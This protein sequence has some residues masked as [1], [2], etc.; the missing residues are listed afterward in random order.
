MESSWYSGLCFE[1]TGE[2]YTAKLLLPNVL[3]KK[4]KF[5]KATHCHGMQNTHA[6]PEPCA[7]MFSYHLLFLLSLLETLAL[8]HTVRFVPRRADEQNL[9]LDQYLVE[10]ADLAV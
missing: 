5:L 7:A 3:C 8:A 10:E 9:M 4:K 6:D 1:P 2:T